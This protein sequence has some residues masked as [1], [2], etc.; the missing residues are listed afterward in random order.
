MGRKKR[1]SCREG[2]LSDE[3]DSAHLD[4]SVVTAVRFLRVKVDKTDLRETKRGT[5]NES[6]GRVEY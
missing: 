1:G 3:R 5:K 2:R 6:R 4:A